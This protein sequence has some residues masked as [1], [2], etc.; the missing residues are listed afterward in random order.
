[1]IEQQ[2]GRVSPEERQL[3][4]AASV[5]GA[6][7]SA[8]AVAA[9]TEQSTEEVET[10]SDSLVRREQ[11]LRARGMTEWP[12]GTV[13]ARYGF[14]HALY[15]E[16]LYEQLS[17]SRRMRL[18]RQIGARTEQGYGERASEI[19]TE[20]A[21]HFEQGRDHPRAVR[22]HQR[23][24]QNALLRNAHQEAIAHLSKGLELLTTLPDTPE[25]AQQELTLQIALGMPLMAT[26]GFA[27]PRRKESTLV[28][29]NSVGSSARPRS[30]SRHC[31][32]CGCF[33]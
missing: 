13:A 23:A 21:G 4:E 6:E 9:G 29:E 25:R 17:A 3:L 11:F 15:Q 20:L 24:G 8:A 12:D 18:H 7:F 19:A 30:S 5:A 2:I 1:M 16:V 33:I 27:P 26:K 22:Y 14:A 10:S 32:D 28:P 31:G